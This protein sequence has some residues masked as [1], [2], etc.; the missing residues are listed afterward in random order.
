VI[1]WL[2]K[3]GAAWWIIGGIYF[4]GCIL[5][6]KIFYV[7]KTYRKMKVSVYFYGLN[8]L[9]CIWKAFHEVFLT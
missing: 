8:L 7:F 6:A 4:V 2:F 9:P 3:T 5:F 1:Y